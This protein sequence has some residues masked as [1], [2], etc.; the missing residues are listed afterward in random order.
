MICGDIDGAVVGLK[1]NVCG[2]TTMQ[3]DTYS[4]RERCDASPAKQIL[5]QQAAYNGKQG[6]QG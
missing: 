1:Q 6:K 2:H 5:L 3:Q 4:S